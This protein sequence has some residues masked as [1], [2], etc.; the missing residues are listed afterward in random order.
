MAIL[1]LATAIDL[2]ASGRS[3]ENSQANREFSLQ[4]FAGILF[5]VTQNKSE[6]HAVI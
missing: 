1:H 6:K 3:N 4:S 2:K 5:S